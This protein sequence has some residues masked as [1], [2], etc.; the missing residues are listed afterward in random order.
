VLLEVAVKA[1][2]ET[3]ANAEEIELLAHEAEVA[4]SDWVANKD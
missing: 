3:E 2:L 1:V 4:K